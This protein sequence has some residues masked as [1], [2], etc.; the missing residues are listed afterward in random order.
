[1]DEVMWMAVENE[2]LGLAS[3]LEELTPAQWETPSLCS[4]W[5]VRDVAAHVAMTPTAPTMATLL[6]QLAR[7][8]GNL[9][10]AGAQIAIDHA[11]RPT[12][13]IV[14]QLRR[15]AAARTMPLITNAN[16]LLM[17]ALVHGQDIA[18]PLGI[19]RPMPLEAASAAFAR[20]WGMGWPFHAQRRLAGVTLVATDANIVVGDG[21]TLEG[22][23]AALL[24]LMTGRTT[25]ALPRLR[26]AGL[27]Q[28]SQ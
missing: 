9:W 13:Q 25:A 24:L 20:V 26:G 1:M 12:A 11:R 19:S 16:N 14:E 27:Q 8:K 28:V 7:A 6:G 18:I 5:R 10:A 3:M 22:D 2:R 21:P 15:D 23:L 17:D 4:G